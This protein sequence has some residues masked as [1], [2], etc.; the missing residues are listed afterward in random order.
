MLARS[1]LGLPLLREWQCPTVDFDLVLGFQRQIV[2][3]P[4]VIFGSV[5]ELLLEPSDCVEVKH[6]V[7]L[8]DGDR[9]IVDMVLF[10][11]PSQTIV[12]S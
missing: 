9:L 5:W 3:S 10:A 7:P 12:L 4:E 2:L 8:D 6:S 1:P 11:A